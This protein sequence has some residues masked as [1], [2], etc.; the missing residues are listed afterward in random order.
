MEHPVTLEKSDKAQTNIKLDLEVEQQKQVKLLQLTEL[1]S[2][3]SSCRK[4]REATKRQLQAV[5][6]EI[7]STGL[8]NQLLL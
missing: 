1:E 8:D 5:Q 4:E 3:L 7:G 2:Q 6:D